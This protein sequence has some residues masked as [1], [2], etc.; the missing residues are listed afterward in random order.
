MRRPGSEDPHR[1]ERKLEEETMKEKR[2]RLMLLRL[3]IF[4]FV[5]MRMKFLQMH[6]KSG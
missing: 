3:K 2:K 5:G 6:L 4:Q 1:R